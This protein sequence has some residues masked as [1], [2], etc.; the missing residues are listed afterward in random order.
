MVLVEEVVEVEVVGEAFAPLTGTA[1]T[2]PDAMPANDNLNSLLADLV[3]ETLM[4]NL[5]EGLQLPSVDGP[6]TRPDATFTC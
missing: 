2:I 5:L 4:V 6:T 3:D 1:T